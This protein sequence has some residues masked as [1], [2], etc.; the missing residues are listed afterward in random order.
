M[1]DSAS[2]CY[3]RD[4]GWPPIGIILSCEDRTLSSDSIMPILSSS[5]SVAA[6][7]YARGYVK[8]DYVYGGLER[9]DL[10]LINAHEV[11]DN[12]WFLQA[13]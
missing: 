12:E 3:R 7:H 2:R 8:Y 11:C 13:K 5:K 9:D 1:D 6:C 10:V 4:K